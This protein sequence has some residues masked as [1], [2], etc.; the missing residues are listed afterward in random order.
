MREDGKLTT[1]QL[2]LGAADSPYSQCGRPLTSLS[3]NRE[4]EEKPLPISIDRQN[5]FHNGYC[6]SKIKHGYYKTNQFQAKF[7]QLGQC[8]SG[9]CC[10]KGSTETSDDGTGSNG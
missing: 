10:G 1:W 9:G 7:D 8:T 6:S 4:Q 2:K 5:Q 3:L